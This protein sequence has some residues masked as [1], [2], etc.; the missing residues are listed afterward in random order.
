[1]QRPMRQKVGNRKCKYE[2]DKHEKRIKYIWI[3][4]INMN[5]K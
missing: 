3:K 1:M 5:L 2:A 4:T